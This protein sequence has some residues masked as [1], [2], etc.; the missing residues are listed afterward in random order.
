[1]RLAEQNVCYRGSE[2][3]AAYENA[4]Y[5]SATA[6]TMLRV[7]VSEIGNDIYDVCRV[8]YSTD[9]GCTWGEDQPYQVSFLTPA[10]TVRKGY[11]MPVVDPHTGRLVVLDSTSVLP[12]DGM[13]E[14]L[15]YTF[16]TYRVSA[17]GGITWLFEDRIVHRGSGYDVAH[18]L[19]SVWTSRNA[20]HYGNMPFFDR[21]GRLIVPVQITRLQPD[22][23]L[24]CP[25]GA[26]SFHESMVLVGQ[27]EGGGHLRWE[28]SA[29][30]VLEPDRSTRG[31]VEGAVAEMPDGRFLM[32]L[33]GSN[34]GNLA[35]PGH[36]WYC[37]SADGCRTWDAPRPWTFS[38]GT[39]F[40]SPSSYSTIMAHSSGRYYWMGNICPG[41]PEGNGPDYPLF[42][43]TI[44]P[45]RLLLQREGLL[46][47][48][49]Y[50]ADD[51][52]PVHLRNF[53]LYEE[54]SS[55]D[56]VMRMTRLW[57]DGAGHMRGDAHRYRITP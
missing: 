26:L 25:P 12:T 9:D 8:S 1:M 53:S 43:G 18:P 20:V 34:A 11:G 27:W 3:S 29:K 22:G 44:D 30:V 50:R 7:R 16:P 39:P 28:A 56:L 33:R 41:N 15:V 2:V 49:T 47:L 45:E 31:A 36:K 19:P 10:G 21:A 40:H 38:D 54:R 4:Y 14:A 13:L 42:V 35:L 51:P 37:I 32:V 48:D 55:G 52:A 5:V 6:P 23:A 17:D 57:V 46:E 24:F